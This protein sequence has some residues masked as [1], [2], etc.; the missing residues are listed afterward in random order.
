MKSACS[1]TIWRRFIILSY[2]PRF[3]LVILQVADFGVCQKE[4]MH[5]QAFT[6]GP[7]PLWRVRF[8]VLVFYAQGISM[9]DLE[10]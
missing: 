6:N 4:R 7:A 9:Q 5:K 3:V 10:I 2:G 8:F 1:I